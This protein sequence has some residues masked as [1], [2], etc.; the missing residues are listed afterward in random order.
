MIAWHTTS[1][2][3]RTNSRRNGVLARLS[4]AQ[5][6]ANTTRGSTPGI[7]DPSLGALSARVPLPVQRRG[8]GTIQRHRRVVIEA[9]G[10]ED[11]SE[12]ASEEEEE[13]SPE[14]G[15]KE[16][17]KEDQESDVVTDEEPDGR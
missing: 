16:G 12:N 10:S 11:A 15:K 5:I 4:N 14:D 2:T 7:V 6:N 13:S 17:S 8:Q 3:S 1:P 9:S